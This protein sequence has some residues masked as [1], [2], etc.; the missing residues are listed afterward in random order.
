VSRSW[1]MKNSKAALGGTK[2]SSPSLDSPDRGAPRSAGPRA[3][4]LPTILLPEPDPSALPSIG[5]GRRG[6]AIAA[7]VVATLAGLAFGLSRWLS[8]MGDTGEPPGLVSQDSAVAQVAAPGPAPSATATAL[9]PAPPPPVTPHPA[10]I[11]TK[12]AAI[13]PPPQKRPSEPAP[14]TA[15][16]PSSPP[17]GESARLVIRSVPGATLYLDDRLIGPAIEMAIPVSPGHHVVRVTKPGYRTY[18]RQI[19][20]GSGEERRLTDVVLEPEK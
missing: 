11:R 9:A 20:I 13:K 5:A 12:P 2:P 18:S 7:L 16:P 1:K 8:S 10:P 3:P 4:P 17:A 6:I 19:D 14:Q 15:E